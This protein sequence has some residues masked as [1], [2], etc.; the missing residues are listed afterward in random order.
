MVV[1]VILLVS[2]FVESCLGKIIAYDGKIFAGE[3]HKV[4]FCSHAHGV[5]LKMGNKER[6]IN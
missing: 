6:F 1:F 2:S 4:F 5:P 3:K